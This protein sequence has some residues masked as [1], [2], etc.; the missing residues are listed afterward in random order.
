[1]HCIGHYYSADG[2]VHPL[3]RA[4]YILDRWVT[5]ICYYDTE[6]AQYYSPLLS[7][8]AY[9]SRDHDGQYHDEWWWGRHITHAHSSFVYYC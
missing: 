3:F 2:G 9:Y 1:M 7:N 5:N 4:D 8:I 6:Q